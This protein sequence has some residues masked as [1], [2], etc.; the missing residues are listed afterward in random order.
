MD[1]TEE[2]V[3]LR[4]VAER[5]ARR[6]VEAEPG[7][8]KIYLFPSETEIRLI[9]VDLLSPPVRE[10]DVIAPFY[11]G[12][13][14]AEGVPYLTA[15]ALISP[16]ADEK[17]PPPTGWGQWKDALILWEAEQG[18]VEP[19]KERDEW[20]VTHKGGSLQEV[21][22]RLAQESAR[23]EPELLR[24]YRFPS[25]TEI[26]LIQVDPFAPPMHPG[27]EV[28]PFY[29]EP[30][31]AAGIPY[32]SAVALIRPEEDGKFPLPPNWGDWKDAKII[33][34]AKK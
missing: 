33:W 18:S 28:A 27:D 7:L 13:N 19:P 8:R 17:L 34:E 4:E 31:K 23:A 6:N 10:G 3:S 9:E 26:R 32:P 5:L 30:S 12:A 22:E 29:F 15:I 20:N 25:E 24:V 2:E 14:K 1:A 21:A 11:F 16:D